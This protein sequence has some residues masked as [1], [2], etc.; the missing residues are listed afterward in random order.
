MES[1][2]ASSAATKAGPWP[3]YKVKK[4]MT[5]NTDKK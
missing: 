4:Q 5:Q 1:R 3:Y 2:L